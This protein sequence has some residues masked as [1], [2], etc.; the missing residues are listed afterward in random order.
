MTATLPRTGTEPDIAPPDERNAVVERWHSL[1][2]IAGAITMALAIFSGII[3]LW[4]AM[5]VVA[6]LGGGIAL[7]GTL[8]LRSKR[9]AV[10]PTLV[11]DITFT[12]IALVVA[13]VPPAAVGVVVAY[14][15][16]VI[17]VVATDVRLWPIGG[18][19]VAV[20]AVASYLSVTLDTTGDSLE[21]SLVAGIITAAV[22]GISTVAMLRE[23]ATV[24]WRGRQTVGRR[25]EVA[26]AVARASR[27]LVA[28]DDAH[29]L[30][31]AL[32]AVREAMGVAVVFVE[33]NMLDPSCG[34]TAVVEERSVDPLVAHPTLD[35]RSRVPWSAMPGARAHLEGGAP[36]FYRVEEA[37]GTVADRGG[38]GGLQVE[39]NIPIRLGDEWVGVIGAADT[40]AARLWR[41]DDLALLRTM[42][43]LT[44][45]FWQRAH[46]EKVRDSLIGSLDGRLRY[47]EAIARASRAL[48]GEHASDLAPALEAVGSAA[49]VS[50]VFIT[51]TAPSDAGDPTATVVEGWAA[52]GYLPSRAVGTSWGYGDQPAVQ[53]CI[54]RG[55][56]ARNTRPGLT[57]ELVAG[58]EV[59]GGWY[60]TVGFVSD[61]RHQWSGRDEDFLRTFA[62][63]V[64]AFYEREQN[65]SHLEDSLDSRD[66]LIA[67]VSHELR[68]PLTAVTGLASELRTAGDGFD[69][70]E[71]EQLLTV[72]EDESSEMADLVEDLLVAARSDDA[73]L[74]VYPE[75]IDLSLLSRNVVDHLNIP[76]SH[77]VEIA[78]VASVAWADP[79]RVRQ[80]I[81]NLVTNAVRYGGANVQISFDSDATTAWVDVH[82]DGDGIPDGDSETVFAPYGRSRTGKRV[83]ASVGLGLSLSRR[84]ARL[85]DGD[86]TLVDADGCTFRLAVPLPTPADR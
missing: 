66:Q 38:E 68:T 3:L 5:A 70:L 21:R 85:M 14:F 24:R 74:P 25:I 86:L 59:A 20:G 83:T 8:A 29:A 81:R 6:V 71:R 56:M 57:N 76:D 63:M 22:F 9:A 39:V 51:R 64:G 33:R 54:Q 40:D 72:I 67:T 84:L 79:V 69:A 19:A 47:E 49:G 18:Y 2:R 10:G 42:A 45:A 61:D 16:L 43:D 4:P 1:R 44:G 32:D 23:F 46:E 34:L 30:G 55:E 80:V 31:S 73:A 65:R 27:S 78:D 52:I 75:R 58:V 53:R 7:D 62:D 17:A 82:D 35:V 28:E 48:L 50:E 12:G 77:R 37:R 41:T 36:F 11:A 26:D 60:G 13:S 15:V